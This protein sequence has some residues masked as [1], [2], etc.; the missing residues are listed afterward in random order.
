MPNMETIIIAARP[1]GGSVESV[2]KNPYYP[3]YGRDNTPSCN[4]LGI[5]HVHTR[6]CAKRAEK[7]IF[8]HKKVSKMDE[9]DN[10]LLM[11]R[12]NRNKPATIFDDDFY[13]K[14]REEMIRRQEEE[15]MRRRM[16]EAP[17]FTQYPPL[18]K[19]PL[20]AKARIADWVTRLREIEK[21]MVDELNTGQAVSQYHTSPRTMSEALF[22][23]AAYVGKIE[24]R[25]ERE[26]R[27]NI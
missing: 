9:K 2:G 27:K 19:D 7:P 17:K 11:P 10:D 8:H 18:A 24:D 1:L 6:E 21:E 22:R 20:T 12:L 26:N 14:R 5:T 13:A 25:Q 15:L 16:T 4:F 3:T 23:L